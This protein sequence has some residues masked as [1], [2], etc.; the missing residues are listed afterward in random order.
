M[1]MKGAQNGAQHSSAIEQLVEFSQ[2][3]NP[4]YGVIRRQSYQETAAVAQSLIFGISAFEILKRSYAW[5]L[6]FL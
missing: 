1:G 4:D 3:P 2:L 5:V 6:D